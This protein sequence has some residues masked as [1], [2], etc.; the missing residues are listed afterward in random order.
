[1]AVSLIAP[2]ASSLIQPVASS[3]INTIYGKGEKGKEGRLLQLLALSLMMKALGKESQ[4][5]EEDI[6]T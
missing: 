6:I 5:Q 4:E 2:M 1:M 3:L